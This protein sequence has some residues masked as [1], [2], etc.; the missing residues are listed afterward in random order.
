MNKNPYEVLGV[1][2]DATDSDIKKAYVIVS[3]LGFLSNGYKWDFGEKTELN[4]SD[5]TEKEKNAI[6]HRSNALR[7]M[8]KWIEEN[9]F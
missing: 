6:S 9:L 7:P 2:R 8:L 5:L 1:A 3:N 4:N